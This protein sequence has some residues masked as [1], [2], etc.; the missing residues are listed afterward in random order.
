MR[1]KDSGGGSAHAYLEITRAAREGRV[2]RTLSRGIGLH[3]AL[4]RNGSLDIGWEPG[5]LGEVFVHHAQFGCKVVG[6]DVLGEELTDVAWA[7]SAY[8]HTPYSLLELCDAPRPPIIKTA[9]FSP[10]AGLPAFSS[11]VA[12]AKERIQQL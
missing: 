2:G 7:E 3:E 5:E 6:V 12:V 1:G 8:M 11:M 9:G 4:F 10:V